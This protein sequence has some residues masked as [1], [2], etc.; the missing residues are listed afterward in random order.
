MSGKIV[1]N[2]IP[3]PM[4][5]LNPQHLHSI[6]I[7]V[8]SLRQP[9]MLT[10]SISSCGCPATGYNNHEVLRQSCSECQFLG[11]RANFIHTLCSTSLPRAQKTAIPFVFHRIVLVKL[12][13]SNVLRFLPV[14]IRLE[15]SG[16]RR[17]PSMMDA[18]SRDLEW[19]LK[20]LMHGMYVKI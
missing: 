12:L 8:S 9:G 20:V 11:Q 2:A 18:I 19:F 4:L 1:E 14:A 10:S 3:R 15:N 6:G 17:D 5:I 13:K 7:S 16:F